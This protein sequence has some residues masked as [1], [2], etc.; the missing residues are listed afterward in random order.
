MRHACEFPKEWYLIA[1]GV[2]FARGS[3]IRRGVSARDWESTFPTRHVLTVRK[4]QL[5]FFSAVIE[6][7]RCLVAAN[8]NASDCGVA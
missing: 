5:N 4:I 8:L 2:D 6:V 3:A 7:W 1:T